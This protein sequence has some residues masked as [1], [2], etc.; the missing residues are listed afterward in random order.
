MTDR[1]L[2]R[3]QLLK[4]QAAMAAAAVAGLPGTADAQIVTDRA[5]NE[6]T[7]TRRPAAFAARAAASWSRR[8]TGASSPPMETR[9]RRSIA[10]STA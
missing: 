7:G 4:A 5:Q 2:N 6:L 1:N 8:R 10:A 9:R 3:R